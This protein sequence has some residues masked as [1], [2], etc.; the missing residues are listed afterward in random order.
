MAPCLMRTSFLG[1]GSGDGTHADLLSGD[2]PLKD[3]S[4]PHP[5]EGPL[6]SVPDLKQSQKAG[7][8]LM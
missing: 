4:L 2:A 5:I 6:T 3:L 7:Q 1:T 8:A